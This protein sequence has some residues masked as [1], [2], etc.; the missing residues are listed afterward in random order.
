MVRSCPPE[1]SLGVTFCDECASAIVVLVSA[2]IL[3]FL[4]GH[5]LSLA[6]TAST[7]HQ[8]LRTD[9]SFAVCSVDRIS[10]LFVKIAP[11]QQQDR[12]RQALVVAVVAVVVVV[13]VLLSKCGRLLFF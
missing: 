4:S 1:Q 6:A 10:A 5:R 8:V 2:A 7:L 13:L 3:P 9:H 11:L 12:R